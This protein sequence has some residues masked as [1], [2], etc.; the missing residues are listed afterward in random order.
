M[1]F[2]SYSARCQGR[3]VRVAGGGHLARECTD[4]RR[5]TDVPAAVQSVP[6]IQPPQLVWWWMPCPLHIAP[7]APEDDMVI[8]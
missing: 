4:C 6:W 5:R 1:N 3:V 2:D 7:A 8:V